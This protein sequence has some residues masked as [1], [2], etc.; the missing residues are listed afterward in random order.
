[1]FTLT[2]FGGEAN[3]SHPVRP[4][5]APASWHPDWLVKLRIKSS[6]IGLLGMNM[7]GMGGR[8][9]AQGQSSDN[10]PPDQ[11]KKKK[12]MFGGLGGLI[13]HPH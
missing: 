12:G 7:P 2:A 10:P 11:K 5:R 8:D 1:M 3:F 13:P 4:V 9:E 6:Y